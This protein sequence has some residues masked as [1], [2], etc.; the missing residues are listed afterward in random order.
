V[1]P[2]V[3]LILMGLV[4]LAYCAVADYL[5]V[6]R[7]AGYLAVAEWDRSP[8]PEPEDL[9]QI[10]TEPPSLAGPPDSGSGLNLD[11]EPLFSSRPRAL[12]DED[13]DEPFTRGFSP[14]E[15]LPGR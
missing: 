7:L 12:A 1:P 11:D 9:V 2:G 4:V 15:P 3:T 10:M 13:C 6:A 5:Y 8:L 14:G